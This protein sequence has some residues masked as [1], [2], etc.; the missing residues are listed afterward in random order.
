LNNDNDIERL[1]VSKAQLHA[2]NMIRGLSEKA[3][4]LV[5]CGEKRTAAG[6]YYLEGTTDAFDALARDVFEEVYYEISP[7]SRVKHLRT[8]YRKLEPEG[9]FS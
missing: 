3:F 5:V 7:P 2:L 8:L 9:E 1:S 4:N 6:K